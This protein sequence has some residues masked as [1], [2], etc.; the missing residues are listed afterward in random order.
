M[1]ALAEVEDVPV[2][3]W[4]ETHG[5]KGY[6]RSRVKGEA[7][8]D[9]SNQLARR[10]L[11]AQTAADADRLLGLGL[12]AWNGLPVRNSGPISVSGGFKDAARPRLEYMSH[13]C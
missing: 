12:Q 6:V 1:R 7:T 5:Y 10:R 8:I 13:W 4:A 9:W 2:R 3:S 11:L